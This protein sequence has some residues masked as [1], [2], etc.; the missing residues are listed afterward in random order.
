M[1][2]GRAGDTGL[3]MLDRIPVCQEF[4]RGWGQSLCTGGLCVGSC[5]GHGRV[6]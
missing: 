6:Q 4:S 1:S 5:G 2:N 3:A